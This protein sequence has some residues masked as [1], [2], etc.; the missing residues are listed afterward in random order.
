MAFVKIADNTGS[1]DSIIF[2]EEYQTFKHL[3]SVDNTTVMKLEP[4]KKK[5]DS[6][7]IKKVW[8]V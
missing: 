1:I 8:Q 7:I 6:M 5:D 2:P 4:S 3:L